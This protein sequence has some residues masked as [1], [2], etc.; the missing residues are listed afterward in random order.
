MI[1]FNSNGKEIIDAIKA[2][3]QRKVSRDETDKLLRNIAGTLTAVMR[4]RVHVQGKDANNKQIGTY[5]PEYMKVRTGDFKSSK[6]VRGVNKGQARKKYNRTSDTKVILSLTRQM[7]NDMS[8]CEKNPIKTT[9]GYAIGYQNDFNFD[10]LTWLELKYKK[11][12]LTK[13]SVNE[14]EIV[15]EMVNEFL[16]DRTVN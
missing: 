11:P 4:D 3:F 15:D 8:V 13:L 14:E 16:N 6:I 7:E 5:S 12:I 2:D 1:Q 9:Y 10:K